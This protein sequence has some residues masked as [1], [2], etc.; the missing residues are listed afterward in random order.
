[1]NDISK[2]LSEDYVAFTVPLDLVRRLV[3]R[4]GD[5]RVTMATEAALQPG[6]ARR[7]GSDD[8]VCRRVTV[9]VR[10]PPARAR[11]TGC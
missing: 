9:A 2:N 11:S 5:L 3:L 6:P 4:T 7:D 10:Q 8:Q 1:M